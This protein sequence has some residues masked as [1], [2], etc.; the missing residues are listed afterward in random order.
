MSL[1]LRLVLFTLIFS[2][3]SSGITTFLL[4]KF[5]E[6]NKKVFFLSQFGTEEDESEKENEKKDTDQDEDEILSEYCV[7]PEYV[8]KELSQKFP[9]FLSL[10]Q[11]LFEENILPPPERIV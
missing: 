4:K 2:V 3:S 8:S 7:A 1:S 11:N 9:N 6:N 10:T 5:S